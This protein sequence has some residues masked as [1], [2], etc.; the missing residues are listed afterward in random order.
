V[1]IEWGRVRVGYVELY[2]PSSTPL[3]YFVAAGGKIWE[4]NNFF[5]FHPPLKKLVAIFSLLKTFNFCAPERDAVTLDERFE[6]YLN[7]TL[8]WIDLNWYSSY[9]KKCYFSMPYRTHQWMLLDTKP[10]YWQLT[11]LLIPIPY[12]LIESAI[13]TLRYFLFAHSML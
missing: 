9:I 4:R 7:H 12:F 8:I 5:Y 13:N 6:L 2:S 11:M 10:L 3:Q 1:I